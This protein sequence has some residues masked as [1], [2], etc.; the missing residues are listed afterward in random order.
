LLVD[1]L[2]DVTCI[3]GACPNPHEVRDLRY[4]YARGRKGQ[5]H[6]SKRPNFL[7]ALLLV[8]S[9]LMNFSI[10]TWRAEDSGTELTRLILGSFREVYDR[11][12]T[13]EIEFGTEEEEKM[14]IPG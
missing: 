7:H 1:P 11:Q 10:L 9:F 2:F 6:K 5:K 14:M 12:P 8:H 4:T 13:T 3:P